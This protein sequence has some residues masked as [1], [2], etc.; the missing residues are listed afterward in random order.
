MLVSDNLLNRDDS[1]GID[2]LVFYSLTK[3]ATFPAMTYCA[4]STGNNIENKAGSLVERT[5]MLLL[6]SR[7]RVMTYSNSC[8]DRLY[9]S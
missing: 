4:K 9:G 5:V 1:A 6:L 2:K 3:E 7:K 8:C